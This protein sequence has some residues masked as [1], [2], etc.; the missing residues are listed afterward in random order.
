M[1]R[2]LVMI[3]MQRLKKLKQT[4]A[5]RL[6]SISIQVNRL[7]HRL[8][9]LISLKP[10]TVCLV[11]FGVSYIS[12]IL[13][14]LFEFEAEVYK[15]WHPFYEGI[16]FKS[17]RKWDGTVTDANFAYGFFAIAARW[18][19]IVNAWLSAHHGFYKKTWLVCIVLEGYDALDYYLFRNGPW[20]KMPLMGFDQ[21]EI[22]Y[23]IPKI[24][25]VLTIA[26]I[27]WKKQGSTGYLV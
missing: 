3:I 18:A 21:F 27:E 17:G 6:S 4:T 22:E 10:D 12:D 19:L 8:L 20:W 9:H 25:I 14:G 1:T 15:K 16:T 5:L 26:F 23:N 2:K 11:L 13:F 24:M 7:I